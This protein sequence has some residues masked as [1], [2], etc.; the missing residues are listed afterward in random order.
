MIETSR[1]GTAALALG[2]LLAL[3][4]AFGCGED[5]TQTA[6]TATTAQE[7]APSAQEAT[8]SDSAI[9]EIDAYISSQNVDKSSA[10]WKT[11]LTK[12]PE[13]T[14]DP[15]KSYYWVLDTNVG[16]IRVRFLPDEAPM[17][18]SSAIYL[19]RLGFFDGLTFHRVIPNF[20]AQGGDPLGNGRGSPGY[21]F[22]GEFGGKTRHDRPGILSQAN[23]GPGTDGSQFFITF[24]PTPHLDGKHTIYGEM[25]EGTE[26]LKELESRR[27]PGSPHARDPLTI[28]RATVEVE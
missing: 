28:E 25:V 9:Q 18:V 22:D 10:S 5:E 13:L 24:V 23:A 27:Q 15:K 14:F 8:V 11:S 16:N 19:T 1:R 20:M 2:T 21:R 4:L 17:H 26:T 7:N 12:P 3:T 6:S